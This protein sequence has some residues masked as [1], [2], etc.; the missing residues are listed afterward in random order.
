MLKFRDDIQ[1]ALTRD[2]VTSLILIN[3]SRA[4]DK[5]DHKILFQKSFFKNFYNSSIK[6]IF[7]L[8]IQ[9]K[10]VGYIIIEAYMLTI[11]HPLH[12]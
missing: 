9:Q 12:Y 5:I 3:S 8:F 2:G 7:E 1:K 10:P 6:I 11:N 4:F